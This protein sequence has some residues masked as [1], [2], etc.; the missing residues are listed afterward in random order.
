[1]TAKLFI[2]QLRNTL[3]G[4]ICAKVVSALC[5]EGA[6]WDFLQESPFAEL[7]IENSQ[8]DWG[9]W[10]PTNLA[11]LALQNSPLESSKTF[12]LSNLEN[13]QN[14]DVFYDD[15]LSMVET[16]PED[17]NLET[18]ALLA[19]A[20]F[21]KHHP[22]DD[23]SQLRAI[24]SASNSDYWRLSLTILYGLVSA[25]D[26]YLAAI[27]PEN[28]TVE[29]ASQVHHILSC[30]LL[31]PDEKVNILK[32]TLGQLNPNQQRKYVFRSKYR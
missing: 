8:G 5:Q 24:T 9:K 1:M 14:A 26:R 13:H 12:D 4:N 25:P 20:I 23:W 19:L 2:A 17:M 6:L 11:M 22:E 15:I 21:G 27:L 10:S 29:Q 31:D 28:P 30:Q 18:A 16:S 7:A 32:Q 3:P